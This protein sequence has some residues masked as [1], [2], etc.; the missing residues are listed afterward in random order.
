MNILFVSAENG[1]LEGGKVGGIG[2]VVAELPPAL[3]ELGNQI[4]V[5]TPS[6]GFL[7]KWNPDNRLLHRV[8]F[9]FRGYEYQADLFEIFPENKSAGVRHLAIEHPL[10]AS[11][12][13][14]SGQPRIYTDDPPENPFATD[15][16]RFALFCAA[17]SS[18]VIKGMLGNIDRM[19]LHDW[20]AALIAYLRQY[21]RHCYELKRIPTIFSI[22]NLGIQGIRPL[23]GH[24]SSLEAWFPETTCDWETVADP[25]W[26]DCMN[27]MAVGIRLS[28]KVHTVSPSYALEIQKPGRKPEFYGGEGLDADLRRAGEQGR[29]EGILNGCSYDDSRRKKCP[30]FSEMVSIFREDVLTW[31]GIK[32][33]VDT[34]QFIAYARLLELENRAGMP[35]IILCSVGRAVEQK[36]LLLRSAG[37][38][39][40]SGLEALLDS[41]GEKGCF[42][43]LGSGDSVYEDFLSRMSSRRNNFIFLNGYSDRAARALYSAGDLFLMPSSYEPCG[44]SQMLAMR[45]GQPCVV[46]RVGG[47]R[48]T[49]KHRANGFSF[50]GKNLGEQVDA[51]INTVAEAVRLKLSGSPEWDRIRRNAAESRFTWSRT[52]QQYMDKLYFPT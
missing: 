41:L 18:A 11:F 39:G 40:K 30:G 22:H 24:P 6:H 13:P 34:A 31:A 46:N 12:D 23:R 3:A 50:E 19:H 29:L 33:S 2:D 48:D 15:A 16:D 1:A 9:L 10:L 21:S 14:F 4:T 5:L 44:I 49:V 20:H 32:S 51:F 28:D 8:G 26:P 27:P 17:A 7:H 45:E 47:L 52:A 37:S 35:G 38:D 42:I 25:R 43:L 36:M